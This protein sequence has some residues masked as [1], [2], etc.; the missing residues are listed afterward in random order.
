MACPTCDHTM[1][2]IG[3]AEGRSHYWC[4]RCGTLRS[5]A[6]GGFDTDEAPKLV[7]RCRKYRDELKA[8][9]SPYDLQA[10]LELYWNRIGIAEAINKPEDRK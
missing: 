5:T 2:S 9:R 10:Y 7:E 6:E 3:H 4:P 1:Q 8:A